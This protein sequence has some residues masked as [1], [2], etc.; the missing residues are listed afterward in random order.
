MG[1]Y[2]TVL[3]GLA[4]VVAGGWSLAATWPLAWKVLQVT[5]P[6]LFVLGGLLAVLV[7]LGEIQD[8]LANRRGQAPSQ[9]QRPSSG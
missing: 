2:L 9:T 8:S 6:I 3:V 7:G 5:V 1:K 4:A